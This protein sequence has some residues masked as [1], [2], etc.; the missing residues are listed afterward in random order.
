M[1]EWLQKLRSSVLRVAGL[2]AIADGADEVDV[3]TVGRALAIG[4]YWL[5]HAK[6][7]HRMWGVED[8]DLHLAKR[9]AAIPCA[10]SSWPR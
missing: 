1:V 8:V 5:D 3:D 10:T 6:V 4:G 9:M 2:L 7:V